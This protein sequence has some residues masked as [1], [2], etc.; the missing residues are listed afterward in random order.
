MIGDYECHLYDQNGKNDSHY[1]KISKVNETTLTWTNRAGASWPLTAT[2]N[3]S[4]LNVDTMDPYAKNPVTVV[5]AGD[6]VSG[7]LGNGG[8]FYD[9]TGDYS[10]LGVKLKNV[11]TNRYLFSAGDAVTSSKAS[12]APVLGAD[13]NYYNRADWLLKRVRDGYTLK[14]RET[15]RYLR[16]EGKPVQGAE[17][18]WLNSP[19]VVGPGGKFDGGEVWELNKSG[20]S[21]LLRNRSTGRYLFMTGEP[22]KESEGGW[23][24]SPVVVGTDLDYYNRA[25]WNIDGPGA[26]QITQPE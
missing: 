21:Y 3:K 8:E 22:V 1:V 12:S 7:L 17:G 16:S 6:Q 2:P 9:K 13:A 11:I 20:D 10:H 4:T 5:W 26:E 23:L 19:P 24:N 14:N 25:V 18:G 15:M